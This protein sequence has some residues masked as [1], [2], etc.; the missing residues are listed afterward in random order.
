[1][2][3]YQHA[4][5]AQT[6]IDIKLGNKIVPK[7]YVNATAMCKANGKELSNWIKRAG[8]RLYLKELSLDTGLKIN[9]A[10]A[11]NP[12]TALE[13]PIVRT[14]DSSLI[15]K[16][17]GTPDGNPSLQGTWVHPEVAVDIA[18][19]ISPKFKV[20]ANRTLRL[21]VAGQFAP[22]TAD[23]AIAQQQL[24]LAHDRILDKPS[25]WV[26]LY[27]KDFCRQVYAW[28]GPSF[29]WQFCY[30][31]L[32]PVER[33]K[34]EMV[35]PIVNGTRK[36]RIHQHLDADTRSRIE[37]YIWQLIP[38]VDLADGDKDKFMENY[39]RYFGHIE[40]LSFLDQLQ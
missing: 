28:F 29:Y 13:L 33:C 12:L 37:P 16:I 8:T 7:G 18:S 27:D 34:V 30:F 39:R 24:K 26:K 38:I 32:T 2:H 36:Y 25:P 35:N 31:Y 9:S 22:K 40:Q 5:I 6:A 19:W 3:E 20:W 1:M 11:S 15:I 14:Q 10:K 21:I 23:A 17:E 4:S